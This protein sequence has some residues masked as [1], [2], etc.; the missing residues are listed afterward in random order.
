MRKSIRLYNNLYARYVTDTIRTPGP[1]G[2]A[3]M[4]SA[5]I[6]KRKNA[7]KS[8]EPDTPS[9]MS[10]GKASDV[11]VQPSTGLRDRLGLKKSKNDGK[12]NPPS[13]SPRQVSQLIRWRSKWMLAKMSVSSLDP[14]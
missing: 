13:K 9:T 5:G 11:F 3:P 1:S 12:S 14:V 4:P 6:F 7:R 8:L 10:S 2:E